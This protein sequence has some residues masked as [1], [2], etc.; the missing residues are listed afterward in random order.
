MTFPQ[1]DSLYVF[2]N[3]YS[4]RKPCH[5]VCTD[6]TFHQYVSWYMLS[7]RLL[8]NKAFSQWLNLYDF[9]ASWVS[10]LVLCE[11]TKSQWLHWYGF[12]PVCILTYLLRLLLFE[13]C[14]LHW[15]HWYG[16]FPACILKC[17]LMI[18]ILL[19]SFV[20]L[21]FTTLIWFLPNV[22]HNMYFTI[23]S[24]C[25]SFVTMTTLKGLFSPEHN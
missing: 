13:K 19:E 24:L 6:T 9:S 1:Y 5:N 16:L 12:S 22:Y 7:D 14:L 20:T 23:P 8:L 11:K 2:S 4:L 17:L 25:E 3:D 21:T 10:I 15:L 18:T